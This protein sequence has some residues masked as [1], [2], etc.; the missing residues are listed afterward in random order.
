MLMDEDELKDEAPVFA[1]KK[2]ASIF[3]LGQ[4]QEVKKDD[5]PKAPFMSGADKDDGPKFP[6]MPGADKDDGPKFPITPGA[7]GEDDGPRFPFMARS[8]EDEEKGDDS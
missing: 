5:G 6:F 7:D 4:E 1:D 3:K 2:N 8:D